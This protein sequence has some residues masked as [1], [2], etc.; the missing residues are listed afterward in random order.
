VATNDAVHATHCCLWHGCKYGNADCAV[1]KGRTWQ[2]YPC[3]ECAED[4]DDL[5]Q[6][7]RAVIGQPDAFQR[8]ARRYV[9]R[10]NV[11][12]DPSEHVPDHHFID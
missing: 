9:G 8:A 6:A 10:L 7:L 4:A 5:E 3:V 1:I 12:Q 2:K 11:V